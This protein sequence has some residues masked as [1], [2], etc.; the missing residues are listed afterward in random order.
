MN[1]KVWLI[2]WATLLIFGL[3][4]LAIIEFWQD[5]SWME[6]WQHGQGIALQLIAGTIVG[7][8]S[9]AAALYLINSSFFTEQKQYYYRLIASK[10]PLN[11]G[12][13]IFL[14]LCAGIGEEL[15]FRAGLQPLI[16]VWLTAF[17]FVA[18]HGYFSP[19]SLN[20]SIY[21]GLMLLIIAGFGYMY[22]YLGL[23]SVITAHS[24][25]DIILFS[26]IYRSRP[27]NGHTASEKA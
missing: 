20:I 1:A 19:R 26:A 9:A 14:S 15:F 2:G 25:F 23:L 24:L 10:L 8:L 12:V 3:G 6:V 5:R 4:G 13:I 18:L 22:E 16:G 21:G 7:I 17:I 27:I 11:Y